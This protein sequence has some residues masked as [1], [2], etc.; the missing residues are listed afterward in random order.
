MNIYFITLCILANAIGN[1][2]D[3]S[4]IN[5]RNKELDANGCACHFEES[6]QFSVLFCQSILASNLNVLPS[7]PGNVLRVINAF[8]RWPII[9]VDSKSKIALILDENQIESIGDLTNLDN[10]EYL[11]IS[12]NR[13]TKINSSMSFLQ[14][15]SYFD[16]SYNF[17]E[18]FHFED[19]VPNTDKNSFDSTQPIFSS[20]EYLFLHENQIKQ[21]FNFDLV[22]A[23]L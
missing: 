15:L 18:K 13:I 17:I 14:K 12:H 21:I 19:L 10:L 1:Y 3:F 4:R 6:L 2:G 16:L 5:C 23:I 22:F 8:D 9:P 20:L 11:N 7:L